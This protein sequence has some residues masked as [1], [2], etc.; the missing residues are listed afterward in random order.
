MEFGN[1]GYHCSFSLCKQQDFLPFE[2]DGCKKIF[3]TDHARADDHKCSLPS[4]YDS[5]HVIICPIC[6]Q[7]IKMQLK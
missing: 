2:C 4:D 3:C 7:R 6:E 1:I 5:I